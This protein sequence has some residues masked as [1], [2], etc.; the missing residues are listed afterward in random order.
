[1]KHFI[2]DVYSSAYLEEYYNAYPIND[3]ELAR[4]AA[5]WA[6]LFSGQVEVLMD[7][8]M[9]DYVNFLKSDYGITSTYYA[10]SAISGGSTAII[11][12]AVCLVVGLGGGYFLGKKKAVKE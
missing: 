12:G 6:G 11:V 4:I 5:T 7:A 10:G 2:F 8:C 9:D 1:M 3:Q